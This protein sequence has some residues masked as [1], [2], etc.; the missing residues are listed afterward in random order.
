MGFS[1]KVKIGQWNRVERRCD[2][3][4]TDLKEIVTDAI[5]KIA[6]EK[7]LVCCHCN[8][9]VNHWRIFCDW[10][11]PYTRSGQAWWKVKRLLRRLIPK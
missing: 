1:L 8:Q 10:E 7:D 3:G 2:C 4:S 5:G 6:F 11:K 9:V